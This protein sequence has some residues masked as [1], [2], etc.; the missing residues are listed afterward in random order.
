MVNVNLKELF[1]FFIVVLTIGIV[2]GTFVHEFVGHG[3]TILILGGEIEKIHVTGFVI[4]PEF[5]FEGF[6]GFGYISSQFYLTSNQ[7]EG[8]I[9]D[10]MGSMST[11]LISLI[12]IPIFLKNNFKGIKKY[13][14][15]GFSLYFV[16]I[17]GH[18]IGFL[19]NEPYDGAHLFNLSTDLL[20]YFIIFTCFLITFSILLK[21]FWNKKTRSQ[22][23]F[24]K[25]IPRFLK[26]LSTFFVILFISFSIFL[27]SFMYV[28]YRKSK[29]I[30][31]NL[32]ELNI[33]EKIEFCFSQKT[34]F[35]DFC[36]FTVSKN[37][38]KLEP[39]INGNL[40]DNIDDEIY[41][42]DCYWWVYMTNKNILV[43]GKIEEDLDVF[44]CR[45]LIKKNLNECL[46]LEK[47]NEQK[48][49]TRYIINILEYCREEPDSII[50]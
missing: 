1:K 49:C 8:G 29:I 6:Q 32:N 38:S 42:K 41:K 13:I 34:F 11:F 47:T 43:C 35:K 2:L 25:L 7:I 46:N 39:V 30:E 19:D 4:Y 40:C 50:C 16:D 45:G 37:N 36:L 23:R 31:K 15:L 28:T 48:R 22:N 18:S 21:L 27:L 12:F 44:M 26:F 10:I 17:L 3:L 9:I 5:Y 20:W 33:N 14:F 24:A